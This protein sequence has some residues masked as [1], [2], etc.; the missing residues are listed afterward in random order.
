M[1]Y[2]KFFIYPKPD[3]DKSE[4]ELIHYRKCLGYIR[5]NP[6]IPYTE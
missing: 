4:E 6:T 2:S 3:Q 5:D 1:A